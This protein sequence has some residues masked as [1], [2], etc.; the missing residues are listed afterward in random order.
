MNVELKNEVYNEMVETLTGNFHD[1]INEKMCE[2]FGDVALL[3]HLLDGDSFDRLETYV[4]D[5]YH[6]EIMRDA[7][8]ITLVQIKN[9]LTGIVDSLSSEL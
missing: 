1:L 4:G 9:Q 7:K 3:I 5:T 2:T 8:A 6:E